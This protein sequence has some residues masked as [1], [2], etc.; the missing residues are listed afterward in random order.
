M[1]TWLVTTSLRIL[2]ALVYSLMPPNAST[3]TPKN[4]TANGFSRRYLNADF[5]KQLL[6][7]IGL[8]T[9][10]GVPVKVRIHTRIFS[11]RLKPLT[12]SQ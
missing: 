3:F 11:I 2:G 6:V 12:T 10:M 5:G 8:L 9:T 4:L 7:A 1:D